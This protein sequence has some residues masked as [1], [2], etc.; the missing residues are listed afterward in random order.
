MIK[1]A[2]TLVPYMRKDHTAMNRGYVEV[3]GTIRD[4]PI[5]FKATM[6]RKSPRKNP[7]KAEKKRKNRIFEVI[8]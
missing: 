3:M 4:T 8:M 6:K 5:L 2:L 7:K 1:R